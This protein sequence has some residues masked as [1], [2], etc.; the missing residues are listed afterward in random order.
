MKTISQAELNRLAGRGAKVSR[1]MGTA[2]PK[3]APK[4]EPTP[5][6]PPKKEVEMASMSASMAHL[7]AQA[8]ATREVL[9]RNTEVIENFRKDMAAN[10][11]APDKKV[12]YVFDVERGKDKL[13][14]RIVATPQK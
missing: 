6:P 4:K 9:A 5:A 10:R 8:K 11:P 12:P 1:K 14:T 3:P 13:I 7:E 2:K